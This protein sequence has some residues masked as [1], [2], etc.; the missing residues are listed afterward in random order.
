MAALRGAFPNQL[1]GMFL[2]EELESD[3][4]DTES[5]Q[6]PKGLKQDQVKFVDSTKPVTEDPEKAELQAERSREVAAG[7][8]D[9][10]RQ[11][12]S[13]QQPIENAVPAQDDI[14]M[15][16][17][18][19]QSPAATPSAAETGAVPQAEA[20]REH[21]IRSIKKDTRFAGKK[22]G[23]I[24]PLNLER[25]QTQFINRVREDWDG[26]SPEQQADCIAFEAA[27][28]AQ[29]VATIA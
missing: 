28:A 9:R 29:K 11:Q 21:V 5:A 2:S 25:I 8:E 17:P 16:T 14:P 15:G 13:P 3:I 20:W 26:A 12:A 24:S 27:I 23:E 1:G 18:A 7:I 19:A 10:A 22:V 6:L 4:M